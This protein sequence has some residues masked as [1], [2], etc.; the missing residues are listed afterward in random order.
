[1][2]YYYIQPELRFMIRH[3]ALVLALH[4][5]ASYIMFMN[6]REE[7]AFWQFNKA[8]FLRILT[9]ALYSAVLYLGLIVA[10]VALEQ[11][12]GLDVPDKIYPELW[13]FMVGVFN[14]WFF[15][16]GVPTNI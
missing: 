7:N 9:A 4:L 1:V 5:A 12:F 10:I 15:L 6:Q 2:Y 16:A 13:V 3:M 11:L 14:T 8:L